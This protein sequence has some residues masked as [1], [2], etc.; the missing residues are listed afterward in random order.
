MATRVGR[1]AAASC[2]TSSTLAPCCLVMMVV[3]MMM[4]Q[5][6]PTSSS[7]I[8]VHTN[9]EGPAGGLLTGT[10][11]SLDLP[12]GLI[13]EQ[14]SYYLTTSQQDGGDTIYRLAFCDGV[15]PEA[16]PINTAVT[17]V[18]DKIVDGV[19][20]S[21]TP[22]KESSPAE[23][24]RRR[25]LLGERITAPL[26]PRIL[27]YIAT[28]C[29]FKEPAAASNPAE[30]MD[31]FFGK[32]DMKGR[33]L[34]DYYKTCS[35]GQ[36]TLLPKNV[37]VVG[38]VEIPCSGN[39]VTSFTMKTGSNFSSNSCSNDNLLKWQ[40]WLDIWA[41]ANWRTL[42]I[43]PDDYHH[44][45]IL[46]PKTFTAKSKDCNGFAGSATAG[47]YYIDKTAVNNWGRGF[48]WWSGDNLNKIETLFHEI[49]HNY[50]MAHASIPGGCDLVDQCD[51]TCAM[52]AVG[53]QG[54]RCLN[55][56]HNWQIGWGR[57]FLELDDVSLPY[58]KPSAPIRIPKQLSSTN[59]SVVVTGA[60]MPDNQRLFLSVRMNVYPYDLPYG[61][62]YD[63]T[64]FL[65]MHTY[66]GTDSQPYAQT[67]RVGDLGVGG[68]WR[69][70][71]SDLVVRFDSWNNAT[72][73]SVRICRRSSRQTE[74]NCTNG[75]DDDC[76]FLTD[77]K[78][79]D[80]TR[81][82]S[83]PS[84]P[85]PP[86]PPSPPLRPPPSP[87]PPPPPPP[88]PRPPQP[89]PPSPRPPPP[90]RPSPRPPRSSQA[91]RIPSSPHRPSPLP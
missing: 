52:G 9:K 49:G 64:P 15:Q 88:S 47:R 65:L 23:E 46:L 27:V 14:I 29:G 81:P 6:Q 78:D 82:R 53:G 12:E 1:G 39:L 38:P 5:L 51:H 36:V 10:I 83:P 50:R 17:V 71:D 73:A 30:I 40:F 37:K 72:G 28:M 31:I 41:D 3:M 19:V 75:L 63:N 74:V 48:V 16:I 22:P 42:G 68:V 61:P 21:C 2:F 67:I 76:D 90:K 56:A 79:P 33:V 43:S 70:P 85:R 18:Y 59:S 4:V 20:H 45:V 60:G 35:Y 13:T 11:A 87:P 55:A 26:E 44:Q 62:S 69:D 58:G 8:V 80:C 57:P 32:G 7:R 91:M 54:I 25:A 89:P 34:A 24:G 77:I 66:R 84:P 86:S